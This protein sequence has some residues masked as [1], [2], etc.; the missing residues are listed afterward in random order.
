ML[1]VTV[2]IL[3]DY[4]KPDA[5]KADIKIVIE[6]QDKN[7]AGSIAALQERTRINE[8][9]AQSFET[10]LMIPFLDNAD[11]QNPAFFEFFIPQDMVN[12]NEVILRVQLLRFRAYSRAARGGG[13]TTQSITSGG[14][15]F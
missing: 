11:S 5:I 7:V 9:Y 13:G 4:S 3:L 15:I 12:I 10:H 6:N 1:Y 2:L 8:T 14:G